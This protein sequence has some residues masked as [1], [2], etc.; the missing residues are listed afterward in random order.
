MLNRYEKYGIRENHDEI[1]CPEKRIVHKLFINKMLRDEINRL[2]P[3][4][5]AVRHFHW[6]Q[7]LLEKEKAKES[8]LY[9]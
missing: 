4:Q 6:V 7:F 3:F 2:L 5:S 8:D 1:Q 9:V